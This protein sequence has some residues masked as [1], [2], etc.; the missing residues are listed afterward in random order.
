MKRKPS[1][2]DTIERSP[3]RRKLVGN[4]PAAI[5]FLNLPSELRNQIYKYALEDMAST[6]I[7]RPLLRGRKRRS[8]PSTEPNS[9]NAPVSPHTSIPHLGLAQTCR[10]T[11]SEFRNWW[12]ASQVIDI[13][14]IEEWMKCFVRQPKQKEQESYAQF[15]ESV[16]D[17]T[18]RV[19]KP[20]NKNILSLLRLK[21]FQ[22]DLKVTLQGDEGAEEMLPLLSAVIENRNPVWQCLI[23]SGKV[24][25]ARLERPTWYYCVIS[26]VVRDKCAEDWMASGLLHP[27][28]VVLE[29][30]G[31][32]LPRLCVRL[33]V[34]YC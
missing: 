22:S 1:L 15:Q 19:T 11:R 8:V 31:L 26:V 5:G 24:V 27:D 12:L 28:P 29:K 7:T 9:E 14:F 18:I 13:K 33:S 32:N 4:K 21:A 20:A 3:R 10:K 34:C 17:L 25:Q 16:G 30:F 2:Q 6:L 23:Q